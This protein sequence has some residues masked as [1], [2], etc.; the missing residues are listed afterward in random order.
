IEV[1][2][3]ERI[4]E[5]ERTT[6]HSWNKSAN[7]T[8]GSVT[9]GILSKSIFGLSFSQVQAV[10]IETVFGALSA[11]CASLVAILGPKT[12]LRTMV[13][14]RF[15]SGPTGGTIFSLLNVFTQ[16][17][18]GLANIVLGGQILTYVNPG[19]IP[20]AAGVAIISVCSFI[21]CLVGYHLVN[22]C[23]R[24]F[25]IPLL[26][27][28]SCYWGLGA[29]AGFHFD[30]VPYYS[31]S[32]RSLTSA[33]LGFGGIVFGNTVG[34]ASVSADYNCRL[35]AD[36]S[37]S[38]GLLLAFFGFFLP[39]L[40]TQILGSALACI[41]QS[42]YVDEYDGNIGLF[43]SQVLSPW[44]GFGKV[45]LVL[46]ALS[47]MQVASCV[48]ILGTYSAGL[49]IQ[50]LGRPF[51]RIPRVAW[52]AI[53]WIVYT[54]G[55]IA[56]RDH[57]SEILSN[58]LAVMG[59]WTTILVVL[60]LEEHFIFRR[61]N[62][63]LGGYP[64]DGWDSPHSLPPGLAG[65]LAGVFGAAGTILG[66][67]QEWYIGPIARAIDPHFGADVGFEFAALFCGLTYLPLRWLEIRVFGR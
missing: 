48:N 50:A 30:D 41:T 63:R 24:Y 16:L 40:F 3:I 20:A 66:M 47:L 67:S 45:L 11:A 38:K 31:E 44:G 57:F 6:D 8:I 5:D 53:G 18:W 29:R 34:W 39:S 35:P 37:V 10:I 19:S 14:A 25:W 7:L 32:T 2:G 9:I 65:I 43:L 54:V 26:F 36:F 27:V 52:T 12:G 56:G 58:L 46:S 60:I 33:V 4:P 42:S 55:G 1:Q 21:P 64:L 22:A 49:S 28:A 59:Y 23:E 13:I 62:E 17:S 15:S 61:K 51:A